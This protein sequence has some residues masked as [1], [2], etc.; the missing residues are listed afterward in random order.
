MNKIRT[1]VEAI[2]QSDVPNKEAHF[3]IIYPKFKAKYPPLFL[4]ACNDTI[5]MDKLQFMLDH[6]E[7]IK[8]N[9]LTLDQASE[10]V[11]QK[12]FDEYIGPKF[13]TTSSSK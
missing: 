1:I 7:K 6:L 5:D 8:A 9:E 4:M 11:G 2:Q 13:P 10:K 3:S 12:L